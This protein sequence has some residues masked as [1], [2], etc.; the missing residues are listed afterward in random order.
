[1]KWTGFRP[2][3]RKPDPICVFFRKGYPLEAIPLAKPRI[4]RNSDRGAA[5]GCDSYRS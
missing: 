5:K 4:S 1:M 2:K 3:N